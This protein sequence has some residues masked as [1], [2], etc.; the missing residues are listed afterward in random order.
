MLAAVLIIPESRGPAGRPDLLGALLSTAG[1][2]VLGW[3]VISSVKDGWSDPRTF[4]AGIVAVIALAAFGV[5][6]RRCAEPMLPV[7][8]FRDRN[9]SG[10]SLSIVLLSFASGGLLLALTQYL[11]FVLGYAPMK[12]CAAFI[13]LIVAS[14]AFNGV[15]VVVDKRLGTG[16]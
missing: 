1:M 10:A 16:S 3:T 12:A 13:P 2:T 5:W 11:Q 4:V 8:L 9:F 7:G 6:E 14:M 15:G